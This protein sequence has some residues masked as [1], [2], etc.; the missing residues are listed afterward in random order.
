MPHKDER[1]Q[2]PALGEYFDDLLVISSW[3]NRKNNYVFYI[4]RRHNECF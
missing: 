1:L 4:W 2:I 3:L